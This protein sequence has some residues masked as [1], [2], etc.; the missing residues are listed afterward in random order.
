MV[1]VDPTKPKPQPGATERAEQNDAFADLDKMFGQAEPAPIEGEEKPKQSDESAEQD[2]P[3]AKTG[4]EPEPPKA[5]E[6]PVKPATL[7]EAKDR[8]EARVKQL[9]AELKTER[10]KAAK[11]AEDPEKPKLTAELEALRKR[12][13]ELEE[14]VQFTNYERS[15]HYKTTFQKPF[16]DAFNLGRN[17]VASMKVTA[18]DGAIRQGT[19][20]DFDDLMRLTDDDAA[21]E[22]AAE[23]FGVKASTVLYHR[24]KVLELN[25]A[26]L[27]AIDQYRTDG[28]KRDTERME[29]H[30]KMNGELAAVF[31]T[32]VKTAQEKYPKLFK[33][34][35]G[36]APG[37]EMLERGYAI[38]DSAFTGMKLN[39]ETGKMEPLPPKELAR[40]RAAVR[41]KAGAFDRLALQLQGER[42]RVKELETKLKEF[43]GSV[44]EAGGVNR[45]A[46]AK[47][48][49]SEMDQA[50]E[51]LGKSVR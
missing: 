25:A 36:D 24:E 21:G 41:N 48:Q 29:Q 26:R 13:Q 47:P 44:P 12:A 38:T 45:N 10:E 23:R 11:P 28:V 39:K 32:E 14:E 2:V 27:Q 22:L 4:D 43:E 5:P 42:K 3:E 30:R 31:D 9:E 49:N 18:E 17:K 16:T 8:A 19:A 7:R 33:P 46:P 20:D 37:N 40:A 6:K 1:T 35:D 34:V 50:F 51:S 15:E